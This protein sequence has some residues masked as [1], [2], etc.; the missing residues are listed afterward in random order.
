MGI[1]G[2]MAIV[3]SILRHHGGGRDWL[4]YQS[5]D[6]RQVLCFFL[7][8]IV[9]AYAIALI[10]KFKTTPDRDYAYYFVPNGQA[11]LAD[12]RVT[13]HRHA[14]GPMAG[15]DV[16]FAQGNEKSSDIY[17]HELRSARFPE[18]TGY[19]IPISPGN[20]WIDIDPPSKPG[21]VKQ[22]LNIAVNNGKVATIFA[23]VKRKFGRQEILCETPQRESIPLCQ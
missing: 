9:S 5:L 6:A 12:G 4:S 15:V 10:E 7:F 11:P 2:T 19:D 20:W 14:S 13:L 18:G 16:A 22:R 17:E 1:L 23:Q 3:G 8:V 21:Q